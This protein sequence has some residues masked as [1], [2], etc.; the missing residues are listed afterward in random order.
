MRRD[1]RPKWLRDAWNGYERWWMRRFLAPQFDALGED[2]LIVRPWHVEVFG[3]GVTAGAHLHALASRDAPIRLTTWAAPEAQA[4]ITLGNCVLLTGGTRLL[5]AAD[6][7]VGDGVMFAHAATV[8]DCDWHGI[9]DRVAASRDA[10]PIHIGDNAWIADGAFI[11]KGVSIGENAIVGA[12]SVVT[13]DVPA[14]VVVAGNPAS[15]VKELDPDG[16]FR[17]RMDLYADP[18][19]GAYFEAA[20]KESFGGNTFLRWLRA[21]AAPG[22]ED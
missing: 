5:A 3:S 9:Y 8:S 12:R 21:K 4:R 19:M 6:I 20:W 13:R 7:T 10:R 2:A 16:P 1:N 17:T 15:V 22:A 18:R 14:N 11:G